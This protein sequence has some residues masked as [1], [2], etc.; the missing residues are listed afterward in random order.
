[1]QNQAKQFVHAIPPLLRILLGTAAIIV[2][3]V[4]MSVIA[5][6]LVPILFAVIAGICVMPLMAALQRR[7]VPNVLSAIIA[8]V[9][10]GGLGIAV[11]LLIIGSLRQLSEI[12]P[13]YIAEYSD[14]PHIVEDALAQAGVT[15]QEDLDQVIQSEK[16]LNRIGGLMEHFA[17]LLVSAV[18]IFLF[19]LYFIFDANAL[20]RTFQRIFGKDSPK[21]QRVIGF[22]HDI[23]TFVFVQAWTGFLVSSLDALFLYL[24]NI[25]LPIIWGMLSFFLG[26]VPN[27][28]F[29]LALI[30]PAIL[31]YI[32]YGISGVV[33]VV[34]AYNLINGT[35]E[36]LIKPR[37]IGK[38][39]SLAPS[40]VFVSLV[41][42]GIILGPAGGLLAVP[43]TILVKD[44]LIEGFDETR[45]Y[46][47]LFS[48]KEPEAEAPVAEVGE[49]DQA[50][51]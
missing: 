17:G 46:A 6:I 34:V 42:W 40:I 10:V 19:V 26:F 25:P 5:D 37:V 8:L 38:G 2:I 43:M 45:M 1:M 33:V 39:V 15:V 30:P 32:Q 23:R 27:I 51:Q 50:A 4:G 28:G 41:V 49:G 22:N 29:W 14:A 31:A 16:T 11:I 48:L 13:E 24:Y 44:L 9:V 12:L 21:I 47:A 35:F 18:T 7:R 3:A 20:Q 36:I